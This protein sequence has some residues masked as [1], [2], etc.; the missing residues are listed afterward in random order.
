MNNFLIL[1]IVMIVIFSVLIICGI[2]FVSIHFYINSY[3]K[4]KKGFEFEDKVCKEIKTHIKQTNLNWVNGGIY[5]SH[6]KT[7]EIDSI[8]ISDSFLVV[9]EFKSYVGKISGDIKSNNLFISQTN[10]AKKKK[11][12]NIVAQNETHITNLE[13]FLKNN[14]NYYSLIILPD[15]TEVVLQSLPGHVV[16]IKFSEIQKTLLMFQEMNHQQIKTINKNLILQK[17]NDLKITTTWEKI[18]YTRKIKE[19]NG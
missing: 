15:E 3:K 7:Y 19:N 8:L 9:C 4:N 11:I 6:K 10:S 18:K 5:K 2:V 13:T 14:L 1:T 17:L 16:I 12:S